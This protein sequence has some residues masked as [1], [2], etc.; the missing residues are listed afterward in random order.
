[1]KTGALIKASVL[2]GAIAAGCTDTKTLTALETYASKL[3][4]AFQVHDDVLDVIG[5]T[6]KLGKQAGADAEHAKATY[7]ALLGLNQAQ[8]LASQLHDEAIAA[9]KPLGCKANALVWLADFLV[10]RDH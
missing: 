8:Q 6:Q 10:D 7:P 4:L 9:I 1:H 3:G 2:M 5:D